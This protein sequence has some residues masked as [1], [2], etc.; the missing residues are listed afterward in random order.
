MGVATRMFL[1]LALIFSIS[2]VLTAQETATAA[3]E[4]AATAATAAA[5]STDTTTRR[6]ATE[7]EQINRSSHTIRVQFSQ[8]LRERPPEVAQILQLDPSLLS[9][10]AFLAK[11][12]EL[13]EFVEQYPEVRHNPGFYLG[14]FV[15]PQYRRSALEGVLEGLAIFGVFSLITFVFTWLVRTI[16]EQKRW[17]R[18]S[19]TQSEVHNKILDRFS[20][21]GELL[22]YIKTPAGTKFLESAPIPLHESPAPQNAPLT[23]VMWSVQIGIVVAAASLGLLLVSGRFDKE[24]AQEMF[25]LGMIGVSVGL[26]FIVSAAVSIFMSRRLGLWQLPADRADETGIVR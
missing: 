5:P 6:P 3:A 9:D 25:A 13:R 19:R 23:R 15:E 12:P 4:T 21:S 8:L 16:I 10:P 11:Y 26:G 14:D 2:R 20:T 7:E 24:S 1:I 22:D 18:L 17:N